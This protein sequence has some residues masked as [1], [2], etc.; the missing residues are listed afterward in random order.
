VYNRS[1]YPALAAYIGYPTSAAPSVVANSGSNTYNRFSNVNGYL[2]TPNPNATVASSSAAAANGY[3]YTSDGVTWTSA[4]GWTPGVIVGG[5]NYQTVAYVNG[6][7]MVCMFQNNPTYG[8]IA[9]GSSISAITNKVIVASNAG[10]FSS[11][12]SLTAGGTSNVFVASFSSYQCCGAGTAAIYVSSS[13]NGTSWSAVTLPGVITTYFNVVGGAGYSGGI[14]LI[15]NVG[16]SSHI[17]Y[18][19]SG[20][21]TYTDITSNFGT[22]TSI[23]YPTNVSYANGQF[24]LTM[25]GNIYVSQTGASGTWSIASTYGFGPQNGIF[26]ISWNGTYYAQGQLY[27]SD[28]KNWQASPSSGQGGSTALGTKFYS[29]NATYGANS[30]GASSYSATQFPTPVITS[31]TVASFQNSGVT[32][33]GYF[34]KT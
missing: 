17:W 22:M 7:Y 3:T 1:A 6:I 27:S 19:A 5:N 8:A 34:I 23:N 26:P 16:A 24:I 9:Y 29:Q 2:V 4:T 31:P 21:G 18:S 10:Y 30:W 20:T 11:A 15:Q 28:L 14:V 12:C 25:Y 33:I 32:P 13:T